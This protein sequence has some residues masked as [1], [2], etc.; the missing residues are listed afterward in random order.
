MTRNTFIFLKQPTKDEIW[1]FKDSLNHG[2]SET[3]L[4]RS[5]GEKNVVLLKFGTLFFPRVSQHF[6][7]DLHCFL[8]CFHTEQIIS[9]PLPMIYLSFLL[10]YFL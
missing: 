3:S 7:V 9:G 4:P 5:P 1:R 2:L 8:C 10:Q 6:N